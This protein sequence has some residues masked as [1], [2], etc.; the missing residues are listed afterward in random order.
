MEDGKISELSTESTGNSS[1]RN[2][3]VFSGEKG[4]IWLIFLYKTFTLMQNNLHPLSSRFIFGNFVCP[5]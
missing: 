2:G 5:N 3:L 4:I 1:W